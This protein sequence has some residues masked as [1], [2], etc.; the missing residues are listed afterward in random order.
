MV[1]Y[2]WQATT[3]DQ[4]RA[5]LQR[6]QELRQ[7]DLAVNED[8]LIEWFALIQHLDALVRFEVDKLNTESYRT[9]SHSLPMPKDTSCDDG[10]HGGNMNATGSRVRLNVRKP[11]AGT[12]QSTGSTPNLYR[13]PSSSATSAGRDGNDAVLQS[14]EEM[15]EKLKAKDDELRRLKVPA[16]PLALRWMRVC[17]YTSVF[18]H[19]HVCF[20]IGRS[21]GRTCLIHVAS[22]RE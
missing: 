18:Q 11:R 12:F 2:S 8:L 7:V 21:Q 6:Q 16:H 5:M 9:R 1:V 13:E 15:R 4:K 19:T 14:M 10:A 3:S 17:V 20:V 22:S